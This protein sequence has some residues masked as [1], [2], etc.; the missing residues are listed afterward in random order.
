MNDIEQ[1]KGQSSLS[2]EKGNLTWEEK[3]SSW[4]YNPSLS[5]KTTPVSGE[6]KTVPVYQGPPRVL[7]VCIICLSISF[8]LVLSNIRLVV[9]MEVGASKLRMINQIGL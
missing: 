5:V 8:V 1:I 9:V 7:E 2:S 4:E 3:L 6:F